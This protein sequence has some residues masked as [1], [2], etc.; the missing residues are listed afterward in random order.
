M[1]FDAQ[2]YHDHAAS[3]SNFMASNTLCKQI[4][5][6]H[7]ANGLIIVDRDEQTPFIGV[8]TGRVSSFNLKCGTSGNY[9]K[10]GALEKAKYQLHLVRPTDKILAHDFDTVIRNLETMQKAAGT[11]GDHRNMVIRD[12][13]GEMLRVVANV[14]EPRNVRIPDSPHGRRVPNAPLMDEVTDKWPIAPD[15]EDDFIRIKY[16]H[17]AVP[18]P[19]FQDGKA[20]Q[21]LEINRALEGALVEIYLS[22][23][24]WHFSGY[25]SFQAKMEKV[26]ILHPTASIPGKH[27]L[28]EPK[29]GEGTEEEPPHKRTEKAGEASGSNV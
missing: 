12:V 11:T 3:Q 20:I 13:T 7:S 9:L 2:A 29:E 21:P 27:H 25:D 4:S 19:V 28:P 5:W 6:Q 8:V 24:H 16:T 1:S 17:E 15:H 26:I 18:L 10:K 23:H 14:F 22:I